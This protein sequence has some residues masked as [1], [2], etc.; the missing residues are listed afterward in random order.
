MI[1]TDTID[2]G[3]VI[4]WGK[5][6]EDYARYRPGPPPSFYQKL[7]ALEVGLAGQRVLDLGTGTG[8]VA[9]QLAKQGCLV[10]ASDISAEQVA[11]AKH[12][13]SKEKVDI[14]FFV[15]AT[16]QLQFPE[17]SFDIITANQCFLY[18]DKSVVIPLIKKWLAPSGLLVTSHFSW[19]PFLDPVAKASEELILKHNPNWTAHSYQG[20][21][22][23]MHPGLEQDFRVKGFFYYDEPIPFTHESWRGRI[24]ACRG[25]GAALSEE[26]VKKFDEEHKSM[27][28]N[29]IPD[30]FSVIHRID[31][32]IMCPHFME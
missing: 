14:S 6:S 21:I 20:D 23:P 7:Q 11:M 4:D 17:D 24:R 27:L 29:L 28:G 10:S 18:F 32:H 31:A 2:P 16:E 9:R 1:G 13:A 8:V 25:I 15:S 5:T 26:N 12:L 19:M 22:P 3:R 30:P